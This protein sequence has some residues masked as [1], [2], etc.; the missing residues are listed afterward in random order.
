L[1][2]ITEE[3]LM[4]KEQQLANSPS[5]ACLGPAIRYNLVRAVTAG[6]DACGAY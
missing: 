1:C 2:G 6:A 3:L 4:Q 5:S